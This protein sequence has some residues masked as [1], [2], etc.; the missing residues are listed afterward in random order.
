MPNHGQCFRG[1]DRIS[2]AF[3]ESAIN[4]LIDNRMPKSQEMRWSQLGAHLLLQV[5]V[6]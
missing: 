2:S 1:G 5:C 3:M 6:S 4:R